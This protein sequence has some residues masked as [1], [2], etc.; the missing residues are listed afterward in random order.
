MNEMIEKVLISDCPRCGNSHVHQVIID[1]ASMGGGPFFA[2]RND[3]K[4]EMVPVSLNVSLKCPSTGLSVQKNIKL[5]IPQGS[6]IK[7]VKE[8]SSEEV[9]Q[10]SK[11]VPSGASVAAYENPDA[12]NSEKEYR[13][14]N[15]QSFTAIRSFSERMVTLNVGSIGVLVSLLTALSGQSPIRFQT[16]EL[17]L[18]IGSVTLFVLSIV[19][20]VCVLC[21]VFMDPPTMEEFIRQK[22][23]AA[24]RLRILSMLAAAAY[25]LALILS[26]AL[27]ILAITS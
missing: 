8:I 23:R 24:K 5:H 2:G 22:E 19:L 9:T 25:I 6:V 26:L 12:V 13:E 17:M 11:A 16:W 14:W 10:N 15:M 3:T 7:S 27:L 1:F 18:L 4:N 21:P 20:F